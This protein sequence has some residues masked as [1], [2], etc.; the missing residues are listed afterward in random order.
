M[1]ELD[2]VAR[3]FAEIA[4]EAGAAIM[5]AR[6]NMGHAA[7]KSDGS[8]VTAA[9]LR[10]N[11]IICDRLRS[12]LPAIPIVSEEASAPSSL[13]AESTASFWSTRSTEPRSSF[14][15]ATNSPS[16]LA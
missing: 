4:L 7:L 1:S 16:T 9:D 11:E 8:P 14:R 2:E 12:I 3:Q 10:A 15:A 5:L 13:Q 6:A